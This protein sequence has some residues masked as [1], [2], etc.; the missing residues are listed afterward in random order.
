M[1]FPQSLKD[2]TPFKHN[3]SF[4]SHKAPLLAVQIKNNKRKTEKKVDVSKIMM[5]PPLGGEGGAAY[6]GRI[7]EL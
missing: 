5:M 3:C 2:L 6:L 1:I 4:S 7:R